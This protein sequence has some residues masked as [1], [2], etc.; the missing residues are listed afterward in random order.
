MNP[1]N[2]A[3]MRV[4]LFLTEKLPFIS[5]HR[6][7]ATVKCIMFCPR[8]LPSESSGTPRIAELIPMNISGEAVASDISRKATVNFFNPKK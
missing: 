7:T 8:I 6:K 3:L 1:E 4:V 5:T 2:M